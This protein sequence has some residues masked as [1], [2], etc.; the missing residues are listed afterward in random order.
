MPSVK[1]TVHF[2]LSVLST[3]VSVGLLGFSMSTRWATTTMDCTIEG[4][5]VTNGS[6]VI[7]WE[8]FSGDLV[9]D[10][11]PIFGGENTFQGNFLRLSN[12]HFTRL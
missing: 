11:C 6:A 1:K 7:T 8:L 3:C 2:L 4:T 10:S 5:S 12:A 9:R